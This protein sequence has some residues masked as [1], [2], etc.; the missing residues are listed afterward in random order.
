MEENEIKWNNK[1]Q[2]KQL[3]SAVTLI[4]S[5]YNYSV[6]AALRT[7]LNYIL[8]SSNSVTTLVGKTSVCNTALNP[9]SQQKYEFTF[10]KPADSKENIM[11]LN[12]LQ[13]WKNDYMSICLLGA[14]ALWIQNDKG[15]SFKCVY[16]QCKITIIGWCYMLISWLTK[17]KWSCL[18][19]YNPVQLK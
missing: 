12:Y 8:G 4:K 11:I 10:Q 16:T 19:Y 5:E 9:L 18:S 6:I 1:E 14:W 3:R 13:D 2:R 15:D 7:Q 17:W